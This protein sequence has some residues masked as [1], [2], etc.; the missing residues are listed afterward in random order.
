MWAENCIFDLFWPQKYFL[1]VIAVYPC[2]P[3]STIFDVE[4]PY[5]GVCNAKTPG[6][7]L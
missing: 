7:L 6:K 5:A 4:L 3:G 1:R 2:M